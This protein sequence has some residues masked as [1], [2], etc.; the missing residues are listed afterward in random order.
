[1]PGAMLERVAADVRAQ[2]EL[3]TSFAQSKLPR[4]PNGSIFVGAGDSYAAAVAGFYASNGRCLALDPY[5]LTAFPE[6]ATGREVVFV[7]ASGRTSSNLA[8]AKSV[9]GVAKKTW[10]ITAD[11]ESKLARSVQRTARIPMKYAAKT[12]GMLSFTLSMLAVLK[13][14]SALGTCDFRRAFRRASVQSET[15]AFGRGTTYFLGNSTCYAVALYAAAKAYELLGAKC[16]PELL[17]E[18]GHMEVF[19]LKKADSVNVFACFDPEG[20]GD[21]LCRLLTTGGY[22]ARLIPGGD[23]LPLE[24]LFRS[25]FVVQLAALKEASSRGLLEP[26]FLSSKGSLAVSDEMIY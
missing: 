16:H 25:V 2:P 18:F 22:A 19:S 9:R 15:V 6:M 11:E 24:G 4:V 7:S 23:R 21:K 14:T 10:V 26:R 8:A 12:P 1:M 5:S 20:M 13:M 3:L 17:E